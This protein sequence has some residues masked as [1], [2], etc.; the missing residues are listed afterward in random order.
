MP[1]EGT[2]GTTLREMPKNYAMDGDGFEPEQHFPQ[3]VPLTSEYV[4]VMEPAIDIRA[5]VRDAVRLDPFAANVFP[6]KGEGDG[7]RGGSDG[8]GGGIGG[9]GDGAGGNGGSDGGRKNPVII[10]VA[11]AAQQVCLPDRAAGALVGR[12]GGAGAFK[13]ESSPPFFATPSSSS[14]LSSRCQLLSK[15]QAPKNS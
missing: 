14:P 7:P 8:D 3:A 13:G 11:R 1:K 4:M 2:I 5:Q 6:S 10:P 9:V 12:T 15:P